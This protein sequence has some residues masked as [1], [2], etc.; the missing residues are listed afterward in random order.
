MPEPAPF[1]KKDKK[2]LEQLSDVIRAVQVYASAEGPARRPG[3][4]RGAS[5]REI[6]LDS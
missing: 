3:R 2:L 5:C 4:H 6:P 1:P